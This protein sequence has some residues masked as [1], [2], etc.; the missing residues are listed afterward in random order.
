MAV[1]N[2][3]VYLFNRG[4]FYKPRVRLGYNLSHAALFKNLQGR[5]EF[6]KI[7]EIAIF[8]HDLGFFN[9]STIYFLKAKGFSFSMVKFVFRYHF[10]LISDKPKFNQGMSIEKCDCRIDRSDCRS[11]RRF[12]FFFKF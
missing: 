2:E 1:A 11:D 5:L 4:F 7:E 3:L 6:G 12:T 10:Q 8:R 9:A